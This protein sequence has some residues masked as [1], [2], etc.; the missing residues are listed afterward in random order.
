MVVMGRIR[1]PFGIKGWV[2]IQPFSQEVDGLLGYRDWWLNRSGGWVSCRV[3]EVEAHRAT[4]VARFEGCEDRD[5]AAKFTGADVAIPR[6]EL[7]SP[8]RNEFYW[9]DLVG[10]EVSNVRGES[11]GR[12]ATL[13]ET[14]ANP[15]L[16]LEGDRERLVPFIEGVVVEVDVAGRRLVVDWERDF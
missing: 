1:A 6:S 15:V 16:V 4:V 8:G 13:M 5:A 2:K 3:A 10:A 11:L 9:A 14:G 12:V 7:P